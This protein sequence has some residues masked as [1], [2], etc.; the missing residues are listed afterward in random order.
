MNPVV[1]VCQTDYI[2]ADDLGGKVRTLTIK[3]VRIAPDMPGKPR[4]GKKSKSVLVVFEK[5]RKGWIVNTT[6]QWSIALLLGTKTAVE[7]VGK[8]IS[9][10][11]DMDIDI[12]SGQPTACIRV[13][14][15]PDATPERAKAYATAWK[16]KRE[17]GALVK[18]VKRE[19]RR[20]SLGLPNASETEDLPDDAPVFEE[21]EAPAQEAFTSAKEANSEPAERQ[22]GEDEAA[23]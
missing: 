22:P 4:N 19:I 11:A 14:G 5:A 23:E 16:G 6:N 9:L 20:L 13:Q 18:R 10:H 12:E 3:D 21:D 15:S 17:R 1:E 7:W 2:A 8:R